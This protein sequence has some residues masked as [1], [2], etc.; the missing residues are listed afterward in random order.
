MPQPW[1]YRETLTEPLSPELIERRAEEG[2][3]AASVDWVREGTPPEAEPFLQPPYGLSLAPSGAHLEEN[4]AE[5]DVMLDVLEGLVE[6]Q[7]L[8]QIAANLLRRGRAT[9]SGFP[10][11]PAE[12][13]DLLPR[14]IEYS[15]RLFASSEWRERK[16]VPAH[17]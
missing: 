10:W 9:R 2:W 12:V 11:T 1:R 4:R 7:S 8:S 14:I 3:R 15:P 17:R 16:P 13:F 5:L 6:D